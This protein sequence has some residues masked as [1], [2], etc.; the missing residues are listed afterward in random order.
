MVLESFLILLNALIILNTP[1]ETQAPAPLTR[2]E[3]YNKDIRK[4]PASTELCRG[5]WDGN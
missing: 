4:S 2:T 1:A 5:G 3:M